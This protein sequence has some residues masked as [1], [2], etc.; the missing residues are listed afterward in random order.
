MVWAVVNETD[1]GAYIANCETT[2]PSD[3]VL[4]P[5]GRDLG[6]RAWDEIDGVGKA[7]GII[8][9]ET[10]LGPAATWPRLPLHVMASPFIAPY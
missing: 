9:T 8:S 4:S 6:E 7:T 3:L 2:E 1:N 10:S 5:L